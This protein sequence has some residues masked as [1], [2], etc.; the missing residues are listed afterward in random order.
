[1]MRRQSKQ[2][3]YALLVVILAMFMVTT[4]GAAM[5]TMVYSDLKNRE[6][7][8]K[9]ILLSYA[10]QAGVEESLFSIHEAISGGL[11][12][13]SEVML[14][15]TE[16]EKFYNGAIVSATVS[17]SGETFEIDCYAKDSSGRSFRIIASARFLV[18]SSSDV[19]EFQIIAYERSF[20]DD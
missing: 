17:R 6:S 12:V 7:Q 13:P 14:P 1:M 4:L 9:R 10:A 2:K 18:N 19:E 5:F 8:E 15:Q 16:T 20:S 11:P 3:G